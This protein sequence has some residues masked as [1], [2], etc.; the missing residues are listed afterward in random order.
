MRGA[1]KN[2]KSARLQPA[3]FF[4]RVA[5]PDNMKA[6][7]A[8]AAIAA[9]HAAHLTPHAAKVCRAAVVATARLDAPSRVLGVRVVWHLMS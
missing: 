3:Q 6:V 9:C 2:E 7:F 1:R 8:A 5:V 4:A